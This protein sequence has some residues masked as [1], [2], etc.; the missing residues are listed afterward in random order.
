[1]ERRRRPTTLTRLDRAR[2]P[3][4][5]GRGDGGRRH[6]VSS[7]IRGRLLG[8]R[9]RSQRCPVPSLPPSSPSVR[10]GLLRWRRP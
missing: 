5:P 9:T 10:P 8:Q 3:R 1:M 4:W 7:A 2:C 6:S